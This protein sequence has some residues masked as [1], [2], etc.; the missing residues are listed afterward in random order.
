[1]SLSRVP[2]PDNL[3]VGGAWVLNTESGRNKL[4]EQNITHILSVI[5]FTLEKWGD[6]VKRFKHLSI[7]VL[8]D[9]DED[10]LAFFPSAV[11]FIDSGLNPPSSSGADTEAKQSKTGDDDD[12]K[13][14]S[15]V[16]VHCAMGI[17]RSVSC[18]IA[19]IL[20]KYPHRFGGKQSIPSST[21]VAQRRQNSKEAVQSALKLV[22]ETREGAEPNYAF[23]SQLELWWEMGCP[24]DDDKSVERHPI[25]Q[26]WLYERMLSESRNVH[27]APKA[28]DIRFED[29]LEPGKAIPEA[30]ADQKEGKEIRCKKCRRILAT[31]KFVVPHAPTGRTESSNCAHVFIE[32][33]SWMRP[34][35]EDGALEG[36]LSCPNDKCGATVGRFA[37]QGLKCSC[38]EWVVPAFSL[39]RSRVDEAALRRTDVPGIRL[40]PGR[41]GNL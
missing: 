22:R 5:K 33:L 38:S 11:R 40:P 29:E 2:G 39:N 17:S 6:E 16:Y 26:K 37:W 20:Y 30:E 28:E 13:S 34:M 12:D 14:P 31:A 15:G 21:S 9:T 36:R 7:D 4:R 35:L 27:E 41:S 25:Y 3:Y 1:M 23:I 24:A 19:Y 8:D 32:T 10:L 18:V